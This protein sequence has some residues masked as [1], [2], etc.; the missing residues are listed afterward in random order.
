MLFVS[1]AYTSDAHQ[2]KGG[3]L[4]I[5]HIPI[6]VYHPLLDTTMQVAYNASH[7]AW[8]YSILKELHQH[9]DINHRPEYLVEP[10]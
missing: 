10:L 3:N 2:Q 4:A 8:V 7:R 5:G 6:L 1:R 9:G